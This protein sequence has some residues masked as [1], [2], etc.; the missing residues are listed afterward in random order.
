M[1][2][3]SPS[4]ERTLTHQ[5]GGMPCVPGNCTPR[6]VQSA[7]A[8][9]KDDVAGRTHGSTLESN[10]ASTYELDEVGLDVRAAP[11]PQMSFFLLICFSTV[12]CIPNAYPRS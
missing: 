6:H 9:D 3:R 10:A 7:S 8:V 1:S 5:P 2:K 11:V 4:P 12:S